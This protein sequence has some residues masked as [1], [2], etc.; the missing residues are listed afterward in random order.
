MMRFM[1][2]SLGLC[3]AS[4]GLQAQNPYRSACIPAQASVDLQVNNVRARLNAGGGLWL[5][6]V[7]LGGYHQPNQPGEPARLGIFAGGLT[8]SARNEGGNLLMAMQRYGTRGTDYWSGPLDASGQ[9]NAQTCAQWDRLFTVYAQEIEALR[10]DY[11]EPDPATGRADQRIDRRPATNILGWPGRGN[12]HFRAIHGFDLPDQ[13]LAP[14]IEPPGREDGIYDPMQGD[15]PV[16][17]LEGCLHHYFQP[18]YADQMTWWVFND[19]GNLHTESNALPLLVEVQAMAFAYR[20]SNSLDDMSFYRFK[21]LHRHSSRLNDAYYSL[22]ADFDLGC[23]GDDF[24][25]VDSIRQIAY[26]YNADNYDESCFNQPG[27]GSRIP[28]LGIDLLRGPRNA[29]GQDIGLTGFQIETCPNC[30]GPFFGAIQNY[31]HYQRGRWPDGRALTWGGLGYDLNSTAYTRFAYTGY[32]N[33]PQAWS[34]CTSPYNDSLSALRPDQHTRTWINSGPVELLPG[35]T[36]ELIYGV[37]WVPELSDYPCPSMRELLVAD[38]QMQAMFD[39]CFRL[40]RGPDAPY[41]D[42]VELENELVFNLSY[43]EGQNN[44]G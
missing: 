43:T 25:G 22:W 33:D 37:A 39:N 30:S 3:G 12:P 19:A 36:N 21:L 18:R 29:Q 32:P 20:A 42:I 7:G 41:M 23:P 6:P 28:A 4:L 16:L 14:F 8:I 15:H 40:N 5:N 9:T 26:V 24:V 13:D 10:S 44:Y 31:H 38:D 34:M 1:L 2:L 35:A 17:E 11:L 27:F